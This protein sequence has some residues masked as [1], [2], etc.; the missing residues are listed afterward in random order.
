MAS[1]SIKALGLKAFSLSQE[2]FLDGNV[3]VVMSSQY[4]PSCRINVFKNGSLIAKTEVELDAIT[5]SYINEVSELNLNKYISKL[6]LIDSNF[7]LTINQN[8]SCINKKMSRKITNIE[9]I[10]FIQSYI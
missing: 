5:F 9:P 6:E 8:C 3:K 4:Q 7:L 2:C 10:G 1:Y